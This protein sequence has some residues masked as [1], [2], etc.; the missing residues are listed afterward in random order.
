MAILASP[1]VVEPQAPVTQGQPPTWGLVATVLWSVLIAV[2]SLGTSLLSVIVYLNLTGDSDEVAAEGFVNELLYDRTFPSYS[3][4]ADL[5][6]CVPL[7]IGIVKLK[8]GSN[9]NDYLGLRAP[10]LREALRWSLI[11]LCF[12]LLFQ[13]SAF[14]WP[15]PT[16]QYM[17][18]AYYGSAA[19]RWLYW[20]ATILAAPVYEEIFF[21]GF[22]FKGLAASRLLRSS[23]ATLITAVLWAGAHQQHNWFGMLYVFG[24]GL[25]WGIA[26]AKTNSTLLTVW[27]HILVN[28]LAVAQ[29][30]FLELQ[31]S[32]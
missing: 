23:G 21:R 14:M 29:S 17:Q 15:P 28:G 13:A 26:R 11:T 20:L 31:E 19:P 5:L 6:I 18:H 32:W 30:L 27:L 12:C 8:R 3:R 24:G 2:V 9:L 4:I 10:P 7:L 16:S 25:I 22:L 1:T